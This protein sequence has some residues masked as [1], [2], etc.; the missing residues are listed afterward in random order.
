MWIA[1]L[2]AACDT[3]DTG[4]EDYRPNV[5]ITSP[6]DG[7][8]IVEGAAVSFVGSVSDD[9]DE[10]DALT[11]IWTLDGL[12]T[13]SGSSTWEG[14]AVFFTPETNLSVG[15]HELRLTAIDTAGNVGSDDGSFS[16]VDNEA[17]SISFVSPVDGDR[18]IAGD[19]VTVEV[20]VEDDED[21][22]SRL[23]FSWSGSAAAGADLP[24][25]PDSNGH[26]EVIISP[27]AGDHD[28]SLTVTDSNGAT[29]TE[30]VT[31]EVVDGDEDGDGFLATIDGGEDCDDNDA[32]VNPDATETCNDTDDDCDGDTDEDFDSDNDGL[33]DCYDTEKCDGKDNDGDDEVD[34]DSAVDATSWYQ[35]ADGDGYG[36]A[37]TSVVTCDAPRDYVDNDQDCDD[38]DIDVNPGALEEDCSDPIDYNCDGATGYADNDGDGSAACDDCNDADA[39]VFPGQVE[40]CDSI[41]NDCDGSIDGSGAADAFTSYADADADGYGDESSVVTDCSIPTGYVGTGGDCDDNDAAVNPAATETCNDTDDDCDGDTDD[42][43]ASVTGQRTWYRDD[44]DDG[45]GDTA[46]TTDACD[47]PTGYSNRYGDCDD[48]DEAFHPGASEADCSD[49]NDYNCDGSTGFDDNDSDGYAACQECDDTDGAVNPAAEEVC[50]DVD[51]DCSGDIDGA[52]ATDAT[53]WYADDDGDG[54]GDSGTTT[55]DCELPAGFV[56]DASDCDDSRDDV[57]P[58]ASEVCDSL[59]ADEDCDGLTDDDDTSTSSSSMSTLYRD[60]D[61]DGYGDASSTVLACDGVAGYGAQDGDCDD[62]DGA[63]NPGESEACDGAN[64]DEDCDGLADDDDPSASGQ[65]RTYAD[66]DV[67][68]Y[69]SATA[70]VLACDAPSGNVGNDDDCNDTDAAINPAATEA[71]DDE[72]NDCDGSTDESGATGETTWYRDADRDGYGTSA[73]TRSACDA[74]SG[75]VADA[76]DCNDTSAAIS[77]ADSEVCD[78]SDTDEDCDGLADDDDPSVTGTSSW[79]TDVDG[80]GYGDGASLLTACEGPSGT[81]AN[82]ADCDDTTADVS[83]AGVEDCNGDDDDCDGSIDEDASDALSWYADADSD[84]YGDDS[85]AEVECS[86]PSGYIST[87]GDCDDSDSGVNPAATEACDGDDNDCDGS[88][89]E[90][91]ATG[92][93]TWYADTDSD[94]YGNASATTS[95]CDL[96]SGYVADATDCDD[97]SAST[98]PAGTEVCD[99]AGA[100]EDCDGLANSADSSATGAATWYLDTDSDGY[101]DS[102]SSTVSCDAPSGYAATADD[103]DD[104]DAAVSPGAR[105]TCEDG[106]D[107]DCDGADLSCNWSGDYAA[108]GDADS[109]FY[110]D[111]A[112]DRLGYAVATGMDLDGDGIDDVVASATGDDVDA[113]DRGTANFFTGPLASGEQDADDEWVAQRTSPS[114][115][116]YVG[117]VIVPIEDYD[118]DGDDEVAVHGY[119]S[120]SRY[121]YLLEGPI[122]AGTQSLSADADDSYSYTSSSLNPEAICSGGNFQSSSSIN[123]LFSANIYTSSYRGRVTIDVGPTTIVTVSGE[124]ANDYMGYSL[125]GGQ[126]ADVDGD[127]VDDAWMGAPGDDDGGTDAGAFY[128]MYGDT[129][130]SSLSIS[131]AAANKVTSG[132]AG[133]GLG[134]TLR[135]AGDAD[136]DGYADV[137]AGAPGSDY[138]A[139]DAGALFMFNA[140]DLD[141][142]TS[143]ALLY[144]AGAT[145]ADSLG[146][147]MLDADDLDADGYVDLVAGSPEASEGGASSGAVYVIY[148][149]LAGAFDLGAGDYDAAFIGSAGDACG[150]S[151]RI[152]DTDGDGKPDLAYGCEASEQASGT[153]SDV[154]SFSVVLGL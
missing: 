150:R 154:G 86:A 117:A 134:T 30:L 26:A 120:S 17:P 42:D 148:G 109:V 62:T 133:D 24:E 82:S 34:E 59:D 39:S 139:T 95:A 122:S 75:Y 91:G 99:A 11:I 12:E 90:S 103:C 69:G 104:A 126:A 93:S 37:A 128:V 149:P 97:E 106:V 113:T 5:E 123:T 1:Q 140:S 85:S 121:F 49:P 135:Y 96:P 76:T 119:S 6:G 47:E 147:Y 28:L 84:G 13:L 40:V 45:Y 125:A 35:D 63:I 118:G 141:S 105:D 100:D 127:G 21:D 78:G 27:A 52:D 146:A 61:T 44:D 33:A 87:G 80:D 29:A 36:D 136:N 56:A 72:D 67:D 110:A 54:Y 102:T 38:D 20:N 9:I 98:N 114:G 68:G 89:D 124:S 111:A 83:P 10:A 132:S 107:N 16:V 48:A 25:S 145:A 58:G 153:F 143:D 32:L 81:V 138:G 57:S 4:V 108:T 70:S 3:A 101:G 65:T 23:S 73:T 41:D 92:E 50:D 60:A 152:G 15:D 116:Q 142:S 130:G 112:F 8:S 66:A 79:Y 2:L 18:F 74:P 31:F 77:P 151:G 51:N 129:L 55:L 22:L 115:T 137:L 14:D 88:T 94:G 64:V 131:T 7:G 19:N 46:S 43:D 144:V 53:T 71:C